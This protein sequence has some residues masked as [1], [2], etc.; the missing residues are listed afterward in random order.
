MNRYEFLIEDGH[1]P[2]HT[3]PNGTYRFSLDLPEITSRDMDVEVE[4]SMERGELTINSVML[5]DYLDGETTLPCLS[6]NATDLQTAL[7]DRLIAEALKRS[8]DILTAYHD[9]A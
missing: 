1:C 2:V 3:P 7:R 9:A 4:W 6:V 5:H 8:D